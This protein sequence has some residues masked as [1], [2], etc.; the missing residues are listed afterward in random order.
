MEQSVT[1]AAV[2]PELAPARLIVQ[3]FGEVGAA[4]IAGVSINAIRKWRRQRSSGGSG[5]CVPAKY[6]GAYLRAAQTLGKDL[7]A[8]QLIADPY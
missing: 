8:A 5:G 1:E 7:T 6:Q 4:A 3:I 2:K